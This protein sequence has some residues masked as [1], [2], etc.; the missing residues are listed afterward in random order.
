MM[1]VPVP[2]PSP[3]DISI[4]KNRLDS[5][6]QKNEDIKSLMKTAVVCVPPPFFCISQCVSV[7]LLL[8]VCSCVRV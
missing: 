1:C 2:F 7:R 4:E 3:A 5:L 8:F 6:S